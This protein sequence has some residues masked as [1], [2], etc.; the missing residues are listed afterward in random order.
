MPRL[1]WGRPGGSSTHCSL[2]LSL[3]GAGGL[4]QVC[5]AGGGLR[6]SSQTGELRA[7]RGGVSGVAA[8]AALPPL[9]GQP[10]SFGGEG[11]LPPN[12]FGNGS[13]S[14]A[15]VKGPHSI[16]DFALWKK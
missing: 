13:H 1:K 4:P 15:G 9:Q 14:T 12:N 10:L 2:S 8:G 6:R 7:E 5:P 16:W 3:S 11:V